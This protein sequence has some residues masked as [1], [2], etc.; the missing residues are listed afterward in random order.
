MWAW[1]EM[2]VTCLYALIMRA[3]LAACTLAVGRYTL[4]RGSSL[5]GSLAMSTIMAASGESRWGRSCFQSAARTSG[6]FRG[7]VGAP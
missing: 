5:L 4:A 7:A 2:P 3:S 6:R 1:R